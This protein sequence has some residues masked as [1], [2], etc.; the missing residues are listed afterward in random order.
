MIYEMS[1][2]TAQI[3]A[4][5]NRITKKL[6][7]EF[8]LLMVS[9]TNRLLPSKIARASTKQIIIETD[10]CHTCPSLVLLGIW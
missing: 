3:C 10:T 2:A 6:M 9:E 1:A 5:N 8:M 4:D 7:S